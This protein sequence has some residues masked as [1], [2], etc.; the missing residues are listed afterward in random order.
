MDEKKSDKLFDEFQDC[1]S[2]GEYEI[3]LSDAM[4]TTYADGTSDYRMDTVWYLTQEIKSSIRNNFIICLM[5]QRL[6]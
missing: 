3:D 1:N 6:C 4:L 2:M 5:L